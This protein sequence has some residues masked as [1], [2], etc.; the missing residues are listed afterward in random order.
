MFTWCPT[1]QIQGSIACR[2]EEIIQGIGT[3]D[4]HRSNDYRADHPSQKTRKLMW[5]SRSRSMRRQ[6]G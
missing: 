4:L 2:R 1:C 5:S 3:V 6:A